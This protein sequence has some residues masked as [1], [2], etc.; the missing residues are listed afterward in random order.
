MIKSI[1]IRLY[2]LYFIMVKNAKRVPGQK[3]E[4]EL[5]RIVHYVEKGSTSL[6]MFLY[7]RKVYLAAKERNILS[8]EERKWVE[9]VLFGITPREDKNQVIESSAILTVIKSRRSIRK[10]ENR[11]IDNDTFKK[12]V[13]AASWAPS[14]CNRQPCQYIYTNDTVKINKL[15][16][17]RRE[18]FIANAPGCIVVLVN[19]LAYR[20]N[21]RTYTPYLDAGA[22]I[23]NLLLMAESLG[24]GACWVNFGDMEVSDTARAEVHKIFSVG[25][26]F[27]IISLIPVG[28]YTVHTP[29][30]GRK[31]INT[32]AHSEEL[33][34]A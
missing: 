13:E 27:R 29:A 32:I 15:S 31:N 14:S 4:A 24:I 5:L 16:Q 30:P 18:K 25:E 6:P 7:A 9:K 1:V 17:I 19:L 3:L 21:E 34:N 23:Q 8:S 20:E 10:W 11:G 28:Y 22:A 12:I 26:D 2:Y 33:S